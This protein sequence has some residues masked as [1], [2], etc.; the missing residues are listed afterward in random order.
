MISVAI[1][2]SFAAGKSSVLKNLRERGYEC[3]SCDEFVSNLYD[4][5]IVQ[6]DVMNILG[7]TTVFDKQKI[8][9]IIF[10]NSNL[11]EKLEDYIYP[12][13][14][15][16]IFRF[17][18]KNSNHSLLFFEVPL[19]FEAGFESCF[20][21][22]ICVYC[23]EEARFKRAILRGFDGHRYQKIVAIQ[24]SQEE[25]KNRSDYLINTDLSIEDVRIQLEQILVQLGK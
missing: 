15:N 18:Q 20:D 24:S 12:I 5:A 4:D 22:I 3:F 7:I 23:S 11:R 17:K 9:E 6:Q 25:K 8:A 19:L 14:K 1:T 10:A 13:V 16:E 2:G 21:K